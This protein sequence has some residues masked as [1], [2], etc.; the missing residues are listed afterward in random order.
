[1]PKKKKLER[2]QVGINLGKE[3]LANSSEEAEEI[4]IKQLQSYIDNQDY[5][6]EVEYDPE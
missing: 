5:S 2:Y 4:F 3:I 1:M 6:V